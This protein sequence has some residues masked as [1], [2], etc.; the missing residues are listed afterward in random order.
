MTFTMDDLRGTQEHAE[1]FT[2]DYAFAAGRIADVVGKRFIVLR[3]SIRFHVREDA[4][5]VVMFNDARRLGDDDANEWSL[6][7]T[8]GANNTS[9][10]ARKSWRAD[11]DAVVLRVLNMSADCIANEYARLLRA[12]VGARRDG[13]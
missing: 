6:C 4:R 8:L 12:A 10:T 5:V 2:V 13:A 3:E 11:L 7:I 1:T 9:S